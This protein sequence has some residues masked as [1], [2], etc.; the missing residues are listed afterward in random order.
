MIGPLE[1]QRIDERETAMQVERVRTLRAERDQATVDAALDAVRARA[2]GS[3]NLL[4]A[5]KDA[6][7]V[8]ATL[9]EVSDA[10]RMVFGEYRPN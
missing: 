4:P 10:L 8:R 5:M 3:A 9:G 7:R 2:E 6:L 1:L